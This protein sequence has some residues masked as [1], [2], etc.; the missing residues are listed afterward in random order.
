MSPELKNTRAV[1]ENGFLIRK[2]KRLRGQE[3]GE[4]VAEKQKADL[5]LALPR[6]KLSIGC[7]PNYGS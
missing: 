6:V 5:S 1:T 4:R 3:E 7:P 2:I